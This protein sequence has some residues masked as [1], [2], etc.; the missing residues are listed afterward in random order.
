M[1]LGRCASSL[2][3][4]PR[5]HSYLRNLQHRPNTHENITILHVYCLRC[6][7]FG[8]LLACFVWRASCF[9]LAVSL[10]RR[11]VFCTSV[12][13]CLACFWLAQLGLCCLGLACGARAAA[14]KSFFR[15][16]RGLR[17]VSHN[18]FNSQASFCTTTLAI[19]GACETLPL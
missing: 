8:L 5:Q 13:L 10:H 6:A 11:G 15:T 12:L 4:R 16:A 19:Y 9:L 3:T 7:C 17:T 2:Q 14:R 1:R 18:T